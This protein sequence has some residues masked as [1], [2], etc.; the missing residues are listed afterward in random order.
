MPKRTNKNR[1]SKRTSK[2][3]EVQ[4]QILASNIAQQTRPTL[5]VPD[6]PRLRLK[7][8]KAFTFPSKFELDITGSPPPQFSAFTFDLG[9]FPN[10]QSFAYVFDQFRVAQLQ[11]DFYVETSATN[12]PSIA[13]SIDYTDSV[14]PTTVISVLDND[15]CLVTDTPF[16]QRTLAPKFVMPNITT[17]DSAL[18]SSGWIPTQVGDDAI[19]VINDTSWNGLKLAFLSVPANGDLVRVIVT[20]ILNFRVRN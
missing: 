10:F 1:R 12:V 14:V 20:A 19:P 3:L 18:L 16:F 17:G 4:K 5:V 11:F 6:V 2:S 7:A 13:T 8:L 9:Q 15:S